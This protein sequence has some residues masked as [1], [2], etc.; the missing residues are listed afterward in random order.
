MGLVSRN[1]NAPFKNGQTASGTD[2]ETDFATLFALVNGQLSAPN[3]AAGAVLTANLGDAQVTGAKIAAST[4]AEG[5]LVDGAA[6]GAE[7][8][9]QNTNQ[10]TTNAFANLGPQV[11]HLVGSAPAK[12]VVLGLSLQI[13]AWAQPS[14]LQFQILKDGL[15][16]GGITPFVDLHANAGGAG[17]VQIYTRFWIDAAPTALATHIYQPQVKAATGSATL[18][19]C[20]FLVWEPRR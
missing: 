3:L 11:S 10:N 8:Q 20:F 16:L 13:S 19:N 6:A 7:F 18:S 4:V 12:F 5:N 14:Q 9:A 15:V 2:V 1:P 17:A